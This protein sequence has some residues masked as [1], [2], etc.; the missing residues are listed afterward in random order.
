[1]TTKE[2]SRRQVRWSEFLS[3]FDFVIKFRS[4]KDNIKAD[5]LTRRSQ[6]LPKDDSDPRIQFQKQTLLP[7]YKLDNSIIED[8]KDKSFLCELESDPI[9]H[10]SPAILKE[11]PEEPL[12]CKIKRLLEEGYSNGE[13]KWLTRVITELTNPEG[14]PYSKEV[15]EISASN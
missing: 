2:L 5:L 8:L 6:D 14:I 15:V 3:Q 4:G 1:M 7:S 13:D 9:S 11:P 12:D 10:L